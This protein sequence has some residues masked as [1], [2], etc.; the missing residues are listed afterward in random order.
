[1]RNLCGTDKETVATMLAT[2]KTGLFAVR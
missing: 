2:S 1:V